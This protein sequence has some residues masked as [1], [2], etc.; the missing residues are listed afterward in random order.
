MVQ[1]VV[2]VSALLDI[3]Q[4]SM[5]IRARKEECWTVVKRV[6]ES[7]FSDCSRTVLTQL[8]FTERQLL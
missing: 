5:Q 7:R 3:K 1:A 2:T 8:K 4:K 6:S